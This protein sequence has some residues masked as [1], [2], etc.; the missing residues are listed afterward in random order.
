MAEEKIFT[1]TD[2]VCYVTYGDTCIK[3][4]LWAD[5]YLM[6]ARIIMSLTMKLV[7]TVYICISALDIDLTSAN[8]PAYQPHKKRK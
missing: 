6:Y 7:L 1:V 2:D 5:R 3:E 4:H 8:R